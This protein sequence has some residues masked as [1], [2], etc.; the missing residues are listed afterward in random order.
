M[1]ELI[2]LRFALVM[3]V[4]IAFTEDGAMAE[5]RADNPL[6]TVYSEAGPLQGLVMDGRGCLYTVTQDE[7][8]LLCIPPSSSPVVLGRIPGRTVALAVDRRR[9][10]FIVTDQGDIYRLS[11]DGR[12]GVVSSLHNHPM[13]IVTDRDGSLLIATRESGII[14]IPENEFAELPKDR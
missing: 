3:I 2:C 8:L 7:G 4:F 11:V 9:Q 1:K 13:G 6:C 10:V 12:L 5:E 14:K